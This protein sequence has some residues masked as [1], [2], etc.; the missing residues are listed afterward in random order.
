MKT[1][2]SMTSLDVRLIR[3]EMEVLKGSYAEK[4]YGLSPFSL[5]FNLQGSKKELLLIDDLFLSLTDR[6][7]HDENEV[8]SDFASAVRR[9]FDNSRVTGIEQAGFDRVI[10]IKFSRPEGSEIVFELFGKGNAII[11]ENGVVASALK[12]DRRGKF[13]TKAGM[14]YEL[15]QSRFDPLISDADALGRLLE[16]SR[17]DTVRSLATMAGLG[18]DMSEEVCA[19]AGVERNRKPSELSDREVRAM[20]ENIRD[21]IHTTDTDPSPCVYYQNGSAVQ[22]TPVPFTI[23]SDLESKPFNSIS[24]AIVEF[25]TKRKKEEK[26]GEEDRH[27]KL[28]QKQKEAIDR[29]TSERDK[30][31]KFAQSTYEKYADFEKIV[32]AIREGKTL[33]Y[34]YRRMNR[35]RVILDVDGVKFD[36]NPNEDIHTVVSSI[37]DSVKE[38]ERKLRRAREALEEIERQKPKEAEMPRGLVMRKSSKRFWF[39]DYRWFVSSEGCLVVGGRD[40]RTNDRLVSKHMSSGDRYAHA[41]IYGAPSTVVKWNATATDITLEE[42]CIFAVSF[43][44]AWNSKIG[45]A[46]AYWVMPEQVSK[47][48]QTGEFLP[49]GAFVIRGKRNYFPKLPLQLAIGTVRYEGEIR[50]VCGP[51]RAMEANALKFVKLI[52][53]S[54]TKE[55]IASVLAETLGVTRDSIVSALPPGNSDLDGTVKFVETK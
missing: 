43:S 32:S 49:R 50:T 27:G 51:Q 5:R 25:I 52:P 7:E 55:Q 3:Q 31:K 39:E 2:N 40:A 23:F 41:D 29:L 34:S 26:G 8:M 13:E 36:F 54:M 48:P 1:K 47:T 4:A 46:S 35:N 22:F 42:A 33:D 18:P 12:F 21:M 45:S 28:I 24:E 9:K 53:G 37:Y 38:I 20:S 10:R 11:A 30:A 15:P 44:R 6:I 14:I 19:R 16:A 17:G